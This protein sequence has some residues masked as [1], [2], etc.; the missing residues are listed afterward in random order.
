MLTAVISKNDTKA[1]WLIGIC[2]LVIFLAIVALK[3][4]TV[5]ID[6]GFD[7]H[8]FADINA[9]VNSAV[10]I[11]L[12][13]ALVAIRKRKYLLHKRLMIFAMALSIVFLISYICHHLF[14]GDTKFGGEGSIRYVYFFILIT[15]IFLAAIILPFILFTAYR[16]LAGEWPQHRRIARITWPIWF[17][18]SLTGVIVYFMISPYYS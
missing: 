2:S 6:L 3:N 12:V 17:Y 9:S 7:P 4:F 16:A 10:T 5:D 8:V 11:L 1:R 14:A 15:H 13:A 18:V